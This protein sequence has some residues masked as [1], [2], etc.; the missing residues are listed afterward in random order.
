M[1]TL[2]VITIGLTLS[3]LVALGVWHAYF[4]NEP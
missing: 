4:T 3:V 2:F 1:L